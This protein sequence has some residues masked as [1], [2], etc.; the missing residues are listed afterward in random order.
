MKKITSRR[1]KK[2]LCVLLS[3]ILTFALTVP[4]LAFASGESSNAVIFDTDIAAQLIEQA[5]A[6]GIIVDPE[7]VLITTSDDVNIRAV[8]GCDFA[9]ISCDHMSLTAIDFSS[10]VTFDDFLEA[11][12]GMNVSIVQYDEP[13]IVSQEFADSLAYDAEMEP[14][15]I[16]CIFGCNPVPIGSAATGDIFFGL[17]YSWATRYYCER[18]PIWQIT[19]CTRCERRGPLHRWG[20]W[21]VQHNWVQSGSSIRCTTCGVTIHF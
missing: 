7:S 14:H 3:V 18:G 2:R 17:S 10:I 16:L 19:E 1:F 9:L 6:D 5:M 20:T 12:Q 13:F 4:L 21:E 8:G 11:T 15:N